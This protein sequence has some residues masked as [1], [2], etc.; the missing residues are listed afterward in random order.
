MMA[1]PVH[2]QKH[3][4]DFFAAIKPVEEAYRFSTFNFVAVRHEGKFAVAQAALILNMSP[5]PKRPVKFETANIRAGQYLLSEL[6]FDMKG[7]VEALISGTVPTPDGDIL[8]LAP[9]Q[10]PPSPFY[11]PFHD[12]GLSQ[13]HRLNVLRISSKTPLQF[14]PSLALDWE[15]KAAPTPYESMQELSFAY[16][17]GQLRLDQ[18]NV[19]LIAYNVVAVD[20]GSKV[21]GEKAW[22]VVRLAEAL[23]PNKVMLGYRVQ[24]KDGVTARG[25][26]QGASLDWSKQNDVHIATAELDIPAAAILH[27]VASYDGIAQQFGFI[28]DPSTVQNGRRTA[29]EA[30]DSKLTV[31]QEIIENPQGKYRS[32]D[33][34]A[35]AAWLLWMLGFAVAHL[36]DTAK[37]QTATDLIAVTQSGHVALV[38]C[39]IGLIKA[40]KLSLLYERAEVVK[41]ALIA[42]GNPQLRVLAVIISTKPR[43]EL[44]AD[45]DRAEKLG[46][47]FYAREDIDQLVSRTRFVGNADQLY[48]E[49]EQSVAFALQ[50]H[51]PENSYLPDGNG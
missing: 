45:I 5:P 49:A 42:S 29:F 22:P 11:M 21:M 3:I 28:V 14:L 7:F 34:E 13:Q 15:L 27:C 6:K 17:L 31:L 51:S 36:G 1:L 46:I 50:K 8:Y 25:A 47:A 26:I 41:R 43:A 37:T 4:D 38:E 23:D 12:F 20:L 44:G 19:E 40:D 9:D 2:S 39:T 24:E 16:R 35:A 33:F 30:F 32:R 10:G 48:T 18:A